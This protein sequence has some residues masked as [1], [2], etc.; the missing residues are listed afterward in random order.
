MIVRMI[1]GKNFAGPVGDRLP[2]GDIDVP[3]DLGKV[4]IESGNATEVR[5]AVRPP[6]PPEVET[7]EAK[8]ENKEEA[9][10]PPAKKK[11]KKEK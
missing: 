2:N 7:A 9:T 1:K 8:P 6:D 5:G 3:D 4:L 10:A 11:A